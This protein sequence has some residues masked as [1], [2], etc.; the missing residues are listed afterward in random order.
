MEIEKHVERS[1]VMDAAAEGKAGRNCLLDVAFSRCCWPWMY[2]PRMYSPTNLQARSS[3]EWLVAPKGKKRHPIAV[4]TMGDKEEE[5]EKGEVEE[6]RRA[7]AVFQRAEHLEGPMSYVGRGLLDYEP[8]QCRRCG[9]VGQ[10]A[11][12]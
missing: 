3:T 1:D 12:N 10:P 5:L 6:M 4:G 9:N 8:W 7:E 2:S 11:G